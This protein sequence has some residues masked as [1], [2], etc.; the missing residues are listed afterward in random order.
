MLDLEFYAP[1]AFSSSVM[2]RFGIPSTTAKEGTRVSDTGC[3]L[4]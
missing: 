3:C 2:A 1:V 4:L